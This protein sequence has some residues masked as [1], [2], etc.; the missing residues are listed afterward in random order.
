MSGPVKLLLGLHAHQPVGNFPFVIDDALQRCYRPFLETLE[1]H[2]GVPFTLHVSGWLLSELRRRHPS[3]VARL[4]R[5]V[6][7]GQVEMF[8]GGDME[9]VLAAIPELDRRGQIKAMSS[10]VQSMFGSQPRG[11]WLAERVWESTVIPPLAGS[12][13]RYTAV[14]DY[15]FLCTGKTANELGGYFATEEGGARLDLFPISEALRYRIPFEP[16]RDTIAYLENLPDGWA[17]VYFDDIEKFGVWPDTYQWVYESGWLVE[18][19][20]ALQASPRLELLRY[21]DYHRQYPARGVIYLPATAYAEMNE[22]TLPPRSA[23]RWERLT[24]R[25]RAEGTL[26]ED[27]PFLR[28]GVW[29]NFFCKYPEANWMHKRVLQASRRLHALSAKKRTPEMFA[30]LHRAQ[31]NDA[32]WHGLF[33]GLYLPHLRHS[34]YANLAGLEARLEGVAPR[35]RAEVSDVDLDGEM[36]VALRSRRLQ[37]VLRPSAGAS[38]CELTDY[39][40]RHNFGDALTRR[41]E[42]YYD[43]IRRGGAPQHSAPRVPRR[44]RGIATIHGRVA[45]KEKIEP[46][47]LA[48]D[49][50]PRALFLD[51]WQPLRSKRA[52]VIAYTVACD[53]RGASAQC[54]A[55]GASFEVT[56][57]YRVEQAALRVRYDLAATASAAGRFSVEINLAMPSGAGP[58][59]TFVRDGEFF[60]GFGATHAWGS[61]TSLQLHDA[62]LGA[63]AAIEI[64]PA[65]DLHVAPLY[66]VSQ[67]EGGFEKVMQAVTLTLTWPL[68][69]EAGDRLQIETVLRFVKATASSRARS[70]GRAAWSTDTRAPAAAQ[71]Q[72]RPGA[73]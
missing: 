54:R 57:V 12:G 45:F 7:R 65:C 1:R 21:G 66:T 26:D 41:D 56:K 46:S 6:A 11:A 37:A 29:K 27:K 13:I 44:D 36:E 62:E 32:Y 24:R 67:S 35:A 43:R 8:G 4:R 52:E 14:D 30:Y 25:A 18:F 61:A 59:G 34:V 20:S 70:G 16:V 58:G 38:L 28:G 72:I 39:G 5:M 42:T 73:G 23:R 48:V 71:R 51:R 60:A 3:D 22:W 50:A 68:A 69:L 9:P 2:P 55:A 49:D 19:L 53:E 63:A 47:D 10:R 64:S 31:A 40:L 15:H 33:G 17:A